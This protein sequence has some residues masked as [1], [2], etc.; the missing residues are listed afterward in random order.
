MRRLGSLG[1]ALSLAVLAA[2]HAEAA[3]SVTAT[4]INFGVYDVF[5]PVPLDSTGSITVACDAIPPGS[6]VVAIDPGGAGTFLPRRMR[7][8]SLPDTLGY[9]VFTSASM[10]AVWGDGT[11]GT[12]TV[13][14]GAGPPNRPP[15]A[16]T[17]HGRVPPGQNVSAG[18]YGDTLVVTITW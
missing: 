7:H 11:G 10:A 16:V 8:A 9:N 3:C 15:K 1:V 4:G 2:G 12:A 18:T 6:V 17:I 14:S 5:S 13:R